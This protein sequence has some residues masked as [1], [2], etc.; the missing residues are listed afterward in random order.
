MQDVLQ[1]VFH[2]ALPM[3]PFLYLTYLLMEYLEH[4][5]N[6]RFRERLESARALGPLIGGI[7]GIVPQC[8]FSVL[9]S[10]LY[11]NRSISLGTLLAVFISTSDEAIPILVAQPKQIHVLLSVIAVKLVIAVVV[12]YIVDFLVRGHRL[13]ENHP[14]HDIHAECD[15]ETREE[16]SSVP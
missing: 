2:D 16:H 8:G 15:K 1:D 4:K 14:L 13:K 5:S 3:I 11:M 6:D 7:L 10:G 12:G 9:A